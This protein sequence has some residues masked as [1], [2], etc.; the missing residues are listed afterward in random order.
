[1]KYGTRH[2][3]EPVNFN[4]PHAFN[5]TGLQMSPDQCFVISFSPDKGVALHGEASLERL[6][7]C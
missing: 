6:K 3:K 5:S 4:N 1:M 2:S 7:P